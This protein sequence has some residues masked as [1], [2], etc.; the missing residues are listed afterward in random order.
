MSDPDLLVERL[1]LILEAL[2]RIPR[3]FITI[4][5]PDDFRTSEEG[6]EH[7]DAICM[8]LIAIGEEF[9]KID[10]KTEGKLFAHYSQ[11]QWHGAISLRDV[12]AH[13]YFDVDA[14]QLYTICKDRVPVLIESLRQ[15]I[16]DLQ[17]GFTP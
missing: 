7:M 9:K 16:A 14:A 1:E 8:I 15:V 13:G 17:H 3:R 5:Q 11:I 6:L 4:T 2:E 12:L 10:R